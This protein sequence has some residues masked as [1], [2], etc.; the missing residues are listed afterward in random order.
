MGHDERHKGRQIF[1]R[2]GGKIRRREKSVKRKENDQKQQRKHVGI[3][4]EELQRRIS[5]THHIGR[6]LSKVSKGWRDTAE[7]A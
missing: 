4:G 3:S 5:Q 7:F 6:I 1:A 2:C